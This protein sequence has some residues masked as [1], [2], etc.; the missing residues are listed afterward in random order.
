MVDARND[1]LR[2][3]EYCHR[4]MGLQRRAC[5]C[6]APLRLCAGWI[7]AVP[8]ESQLK[9]AAD[10]RF[11][12]YD[13]GVDFLAGSQ[14]VVVRIRF[15]SRSSSRVKAV[16]SNLASAK[17]ASRSVMPSENNTLA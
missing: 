11:S 9:A 6:E 8:E 14:L 7:A 16:L 10:L 2:R 5:H 4:E 12:E 1:H 15:G 3:S 17:S 13:E